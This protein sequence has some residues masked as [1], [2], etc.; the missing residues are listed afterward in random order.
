MQMGVYTMKQL[1][2][3]KF[4]IVAD[5]NLV[6]SLIAM[7]EAYE[8]IEEKD[9]PRIEEYIKERIVDEDLL[10]IGMQIVN[11]KKDKMNHVEI[12]ERAENALNEY[13]DR[14]DAE[15]IARQEAQ[16]V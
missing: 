7:V 10:K 4:S 16:N 6:N 12:K 15:R 14:K 11:D 2:M 9:F 13:M 5:F 3:S 1:D 8:S